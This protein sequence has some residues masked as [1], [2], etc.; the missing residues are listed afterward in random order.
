MILSTADLAQVAGKVV[1][2]DGSFDPLHDGHIEYF[3]QA[4]GLGLPVLCNVAP[5]SWTEKKH[6]VMLEQAKRAVVLDA[7]RF[8]SYVVIADLSTAAT[9]EAV[10]PKIYAKGRDWKARGGIPREEQSICDRLEIEVVYLDT[11]LNSST[12]LLGRIKGGLEK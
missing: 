4:A 6:P 5:D 1:M 11:V 8:I 7:I 3:R 10:H 9:L 12:E 2:V